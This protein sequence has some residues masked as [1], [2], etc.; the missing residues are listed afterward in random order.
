ML[1]K[2]TDRILE[3]TGASVRP[4]ALSKDSIFPITDFGA[5]PQ[6]TPA[7]NARAINSAIQAA[8]LHGGTVVFP[9]IGRAHV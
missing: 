8:S 5:S 7:D 2:T 1:N 4:E 9:E 6:A 3:A